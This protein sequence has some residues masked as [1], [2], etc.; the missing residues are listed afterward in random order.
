MTSAVVRQ[1]RLYPLRIPLRQRVVHAAAE[2][3]VAE[4]VVV[5]VELGNG[6]TGYGETLPRPYVTG[7]SVEGVLELGSGPLGAALLSFHPPSFPDALEAIEALPWRDAEGRCF[8]AA[9]CALELALL[10]A[11]LRSFRRGMD[12]VVR[13]MGLPGFGGP[14]SLG[15]IRFSGV[16]AAA[17]AEAALRQL[18]LMYWGG[19]RHFKLKVGEPGDHDRLGRAAAYL[20]RAI[21]HRGATLRVDANGAWS[22]DQAI[23]W[24]AVSGD[25]PIA[26][27]EQPLPRGAEDQLPVIRDLFAGPIMH[28]ESLITEEDAR[29]LIELGVADF[30][31]IRISKCGGLL[32]SLRL[33]A[34]ARRENVGIQL[35]C[36]VGET[37]IL[38]A[39]A[40]RFLQ[41][42][43]GVRWAEGCFGSYLLSSDVVARGLRF[44]YAGRPPRL[45][46]SGSGIEVDAQRLEQLCPAGPIVM[47]L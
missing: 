32:P 6:V 20:R 21:E 40:V 28:D 30:F 15:R 19:L 2:R 8:P 34:L 24:L 43:P 38:S 33:A 13:W 41:V 37:S 18:R 12:D 4:P 11:A 42:C 10:D 9:R 17:G 25:L 44:G 16:L 1:I 23:D 7:E 27:L 14:G 46:D 26:A 22:K 5:A 39:A 3:H 35:G 31:N 36:M 45:P 29:R 47:N